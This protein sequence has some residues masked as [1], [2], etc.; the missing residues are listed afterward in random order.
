MAK[1]VTNSSRNETRRG[2]LARAVTLVNNR[3]QGWYTIALKLAAFYGVWIAGAYAVYSYTS[4]PA[5]QQIAASF[6][7]LGWLFVGVTVLLGV[8]LGVMGLLQDA[9]LR[10]KAKVAETR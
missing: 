7:W 8:F 1:L 10:A 6:Y 2:S 3:V 9:R 5:L 4:V